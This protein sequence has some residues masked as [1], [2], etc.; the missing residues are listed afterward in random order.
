MKTV[1]ASTMFCRC[2]QKLILLLEN[3]AISFILGYFYNTDDLLASLK[4]FT[5]VKALII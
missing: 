1:F 3:N 4:V 5:L 2:C